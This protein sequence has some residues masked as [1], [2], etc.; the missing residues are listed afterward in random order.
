MIKLLAAAV[1]IVAIATPALASIQDVEPAGFSCEGRDGDATIF[2]DTKE[3]MVYLKINDQL[4]LKEEI[5]Y[6]W[7]VNKYGHG[8]G[9]PPF[10]FTGMTWGAAESR[11]GLPT[12]NGPT[13]TSRTLQ[14]HGNH[15]V[16]TYGYREKH[17]NPDGSVT[18]LW[19]VVQYK[20][21]CAGDYDA[22]VKLLEE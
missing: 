17:K 6:W 10:Y 4:T 7:Q 22:G 14:Q 9:K 18:P 13:S 15:W 19:L 3:G 20:G 11:D 2:F 1:V 8:G 5:K 16:L 21:D 12:D